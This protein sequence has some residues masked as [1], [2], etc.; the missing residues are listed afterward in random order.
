MFNVTW[1]G[2]SHGHYVEVGESPSVTSEAVVTDE[3]FI[4]KY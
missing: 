2:I 1:E 3:V 4:E